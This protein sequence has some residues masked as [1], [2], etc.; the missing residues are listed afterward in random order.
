MISR[1]AGLGF[2]V[3]GCDGGRGTFGKRAGAAHPRRARLS[4]YAR[5]VRH[6]TLHCRV[7]PP[8]TAAAGE[9][10]A[11]VARQRAHGS[12]VRWGVRQMSNVPGPPKAGTIAGKVHPNTLP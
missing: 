11:G 8:S 6:G 12:E 7:E 9:G 4:A 5:D 2:S 1:P 3:E 10:A